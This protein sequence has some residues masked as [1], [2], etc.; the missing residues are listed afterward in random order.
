M[1]TDTKSPSERIEY[2][3]ALRGLTMILVVFCHIEMTTFGF[4]DPGFTNIGSFFISFHLPLFFYIS[5]LNAY[6]ANIQWN[7]HTLLTST[8]K[9]AFALIIPAFFFGI[10]YT[11]VLLD[12]NIYD[13]LAHNAKHGYWFTIALFE[14]FLIVYTTNACLFNNDSKIYKRRMTIALIAISG[15]LFLIK[16]PIKMHPTLNNIGN[17]LTLHH[18]FNYF[19]YFAFGYICAMYKE[20]FNKILRNRLFSVAI[21]IFFAALFYIKRFHTS[22]LISGSMDVWRVLDIFLEMIIGYLGTLAVFNIFRTNHKL[23]TAEKKIG[24]AI[25]TIGKRTLDIYLLHYFLIFIDIHQIGDMLLK[26]DSAILE[27]TIGLTTTLIVIGLCLIISR[28]LRTS[29]L[30]AKWLFGAKSK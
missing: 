5:G 24:K 20:Q 13:F 4:N 17:V 28:I 11:Y 23:F 2:I 12:K 7:V 22:T 26:K 25:Q 15:F 8:Y 10:I 6:K 21:I 29:P 18:S 19:Q 30:M 9:K 27:L 3:D 14:I 1:T 16:I